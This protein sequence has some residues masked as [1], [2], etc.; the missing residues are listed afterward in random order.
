MLTGQSKYSLMYQRY[1]ISNL[2][3]CRQYR[4]AQKTKEQ[5]QMSELEELEEENTRLRMQE[6][7][8]RGTL[9][10]VKEVYLDLIV[11]GRVRFIK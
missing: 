3:R 8:M 5:S 7:S 4:V 2:L 6:E 11:K 1:N 9:A 10:R